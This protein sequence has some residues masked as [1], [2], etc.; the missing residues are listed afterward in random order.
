[1]NFVLD[2]SAETN[3]ILSA[4]RNG[5]QGSAMDWNMAEKLAQ[6]FSSFNAMPVKKQQLKELCHEIQPN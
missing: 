3:A 1:M 6:P 2:R 5:W 4:L